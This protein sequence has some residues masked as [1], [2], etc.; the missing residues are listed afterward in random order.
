MATILPRA[1]KCPPATH[2]TAT[3]TSV[4]DVVFHHCITPALLDAWEARIPPEARSHD[5][6]RRRCWIAAEYLDVALALAE[7]Y[8]DVELIDGPRS[9]ATHCLCRATLTQLRRRA[10]RAA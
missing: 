8:H 2:A 1:G 9:R 3:L 5:P 6:E 10:R 7:R 4:G